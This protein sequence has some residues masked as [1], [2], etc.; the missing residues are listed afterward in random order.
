MAKR[1]RKSAVGAGLTRMLPSRF[2]PGVPGDLHATTD[3]C[4]PDVSPVAIERSAAPALSHV[5]PVFDDLQPVH[6]ARMTVR[7][8]LAKGLIPFPRSRV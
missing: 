8:L 7:S 2:A 5:R 6:L 4:I 3:P 1:H